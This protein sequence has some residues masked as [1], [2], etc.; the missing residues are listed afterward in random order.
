MRMSHIYQPVMLKTLLERGGEANL[1]TIAAAF[2][3][4]DESQLEYY[5]E[6]TKVMPGKVLSKHG[7]V[8]RSGT[9]YRLKPDIA[10]LSPREREELVQYCDEAARQRKSGTL[11]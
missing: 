10:E 6:I 9:S 4:H 2:L 5:E 11:S 3:A 8:E 7:L 1:R